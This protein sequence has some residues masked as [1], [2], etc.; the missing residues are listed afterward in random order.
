MYWFNDNW[1]LKIVEK[2][3]I[4]INFP[5]DRL[6]D[7]SSSLYWAQQQL[8]ISQKIQGQGMTMHILRLED[9]WCWKIRLSQVWNLQPNDPMQNKFAIRW[10]MTLITP[11]NLST[12]ISWILIQTTNCKRW[13]A[14]QSDDMEASEENNPQRWLWWRESQLERFYSVLCSMRAF[15]DCL[16]CFRIWPRS[17]PALSFPEGGSTFSKIKTSVSAI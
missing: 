15:L 14:G 9:I 16:K 4:Q 7:N 3:I 6:G 10:E 8:Q 2:N 17:S 5:C 11:T 13:E 1:R 12:L